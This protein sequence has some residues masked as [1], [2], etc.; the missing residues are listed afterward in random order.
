VPL[1]GYD[2]EDESTVGPQPHQYVSDS[3]EE[4]VASVKEEE[5]DW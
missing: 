5:D 1:I 2:D 3:K 4:D